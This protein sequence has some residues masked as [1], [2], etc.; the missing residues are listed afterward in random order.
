M[1]LLKKGQEV[2][3]DLEEKHNDLQKRLE[4]K[5]PDTSTPNATPSKDDNTATLRDKVNQPSKDDN[6]DKEYRPPVKPITQ[7]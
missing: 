7:K 1:G 5:Q 6:T 4:E 3:A 2:P